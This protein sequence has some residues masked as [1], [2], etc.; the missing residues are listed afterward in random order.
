MQ[1]MKESFVV[2]VI[3]YILILLCMMV[4]VFSAMMVFI[5]ASNQ[6]YTKGRAACL[7][8]IYKDTLDY[9]CYQLS[10]AVYEYEDSAADS[11]ET[12]IEDEDGSI[13]ESSTENLD[14]KSLSDSEEELL[15]GERDADG[16]GYT[17]TRPVTDEDG[18]TET[19][20]DGNTKMTEV[21][22]VHPELLQK[23]KQGSGYLW[24]SAIHNDMTINVC[25]IK[26]PDS[27][28]LPDDVFM[29]YRSMEKI[30]TF[31]IPAIIAVA[32]CSI[33]ALCL[34]I[35]LVTTTGR[36][37][38]DAE[39]SIL[40]K[41]PVEIV[42]FLAGCGVMATLGIAF[43]T[44]YENNI[45]MLCAAVA[46]ATLVISSILLAVVLFLVVKMRDHSLWPSSILCRLW[47]LWKNRI[48]KFFRG[49]PSVWKAA[50]LM[51][52]MLILNLFCLSIMSGFAWLFWAGAVFVVGVLFA[53]KMKRLKEGGKHL[54]EGDLSYQ[55]DTR[56]LR[57][58][59]REH[60]EN[61]NH[62]REGISVAVEE[63]MKSERFRNELITNVSHDIKTPLTSIIN[64]VDF[65]KKEEIDNKQAQ[66][67]IDVLDRQANRLK[68][69]TEDLVE[70]SK[71]ATGNIRLERMPC[72]VG[73]MM[74][75]VMGEYQEKMQGADLTMIP[76]QPEEN[77]E[78]LADGRSLW[79]VFDNLLNNICKYSQPGTRVYQT[80][81]R[82]NDKA[83][84]IYRN[85]S[86]YELNISEEELM[87]RFVRGDKSRHTEGSGLGLSIARNLVELQG[88]TF[89]IHIDGDLFKVIIEFPLYHG[90]PYAED[91][92]V[93]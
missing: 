1:K 31:R 39:R 20:A 30:Y 55:I 29:K 83:V 87:E 14:L 71:A 26:D 12:T 17:I 11:E 42:L 44:N 59:L 65:L 89:R 33:M 88:G 32:V 9:S 52:G 38:R 61:L 45:D 3:A 58:D 79:R 62:I 40:T 46:G 35:F 48:C 74:M 68:K 78:I 93:K 73:V 75:Q 8:D 50:L 6:W 76:T 72:R 56:D 49:I 43:T 4:T 85:T 23:A 41:T 36:R 5:N 92:A 90:R 24:T 27:T 69:L 84:I 19:D 60:A 16:F 54:A 51:T 7:H 53:E 70:A 34:F 86:A 15:Y 2:K 57:G 77:L 10:S 82:Q 22:S 64:Y 66:E 21:R 80:L 63:Q 28:S 81:E 18:K 37:K 13:L 91:P 67:Y 25:M 47:R